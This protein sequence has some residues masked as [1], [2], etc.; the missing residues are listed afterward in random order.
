MILSFINFGCKY[1]F[2]FA[3]ITHRQLI[4]LFLKHV[5]LSTFA[6]AITFVI[7]SSED[8]VIGLY[9]MIIY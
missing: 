4:I 6:T 1:K 3:V 2:P 8:E 9:K 5:C 7:V